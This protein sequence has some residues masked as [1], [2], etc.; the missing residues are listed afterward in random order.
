METPPQAEPQLSTISPRRT[1]SSQTWRLLAALALAIAGGVLARHFGA[2]GIATAQT[3]G[4]FGQ[5]WL[6][7]LRMTLIPLV[8]CLMTAGIASIAK[9]A[10][11]GVVAR[12]AITVF[13]LLLILGSVLGALTML[14]LMAL[15]P[16]SVLH[17]A[18]AAASTS[19]SAPPS[20]LSEFVNLIPTNPITAAAESAV[21]PLIVFAA[22]F[23]VA[24][25][26]IKAEWTTLL[27]D[28]LNAIA[29]AMLTIVGWIL[30]LAPF[31]IFFLLLS[32]V[33]TVGSDAARG[34]LQFLVLASIVPAVGVIIAQIVGSLSGVGPARFARAALAPQT[35][36]ATTQ[37]STA[38][39]P[40]LLE[41]ATTL[42]LPAEIV[43]SIMPL[44]VAT[45]RFGNVFAA[46]AT[47]L[48]GAHLFG[49]HPSAA[50]IAAA[51]GIGVLTNVGSVGVPGAAV[52]LAAWGPI[53][54]TLGAP[55][56]ALTLYIA[57]IT[58]PDIFITTGNVTA[59]LASTSLIATLV[60]KSTRAKVSA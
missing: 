38:C 49:I 17:V 36:A 40:A 1:G 7:A 44:A 8:F 28:V 26:R 6:N 22:F 35:L 60:A 41:A 55:L 19:Q 30:R 58:V 37:S 5:L 15:W 48:V 51:I 14:G 57:I 45:F 16:V 46:V 50:Q 11:G 21:A 13:V 42:R 33:A 34:L 56:E 47:G 54:V 4:Q 52:L 10:S 53:F 39:L 32:T 31:G 3:F 2:R 43:S 29:A 24:I 9:S 18:A 20:L 25:V 12:I 59:D 27:L 23:G